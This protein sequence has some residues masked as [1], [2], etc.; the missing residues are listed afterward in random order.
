M[1]LQCTEL[2]QLHVNILAI[3][4]YLSM[5]TQWKFHSQGPGAHWYHLV[6]SSTIPIDADHPKQS[7][8]N[9]A[10]EA[11]DRVPT[12]DFSGGLRL[13]LDLGKNRVRNRKPNHEVCVNLTYRLRFQGGGQRRKTQKPKEFSATV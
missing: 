11:E 2:H 5:P 12:G 1:P 7:G 8:A 9:S 4:K 6:L 3:L 10:N 13:P